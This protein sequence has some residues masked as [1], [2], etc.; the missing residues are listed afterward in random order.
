MNEISIAYKVLL[1]AAGSVVAIGGAVIMINKLFK[2]QRVLK[3]E[4]EQ[5]KQ[6]EKKIQETLDEVIE[7]N[8]KL[9]KG[10]VALLNHVATGNHIAQVTKARNDLN[11]HLVDNL[12]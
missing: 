5:L 7:T 3:K 9:C 11:E 8:K 10:V 4:V 6:N 12:C 1:G 2:P